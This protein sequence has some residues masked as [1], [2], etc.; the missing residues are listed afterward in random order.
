MTIYRISTSLILAAS[1]FFVLPFSSVGPGGINFN[2][3]WHTR[4]AHHFFSPSLLS[5]PFP[6]SSVPRRRPLN[7]LG[8]LQRVPEELVHGERR[9]ESQAWRRQLGNVVGRRGARWGGEGLAA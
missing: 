6:L 2:N 9:T 4:Y 3:Y 1:S 5:L 7:V 8:L